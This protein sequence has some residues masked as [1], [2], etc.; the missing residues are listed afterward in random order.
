MITT[1]EL[2]L[3]LILSAIIGGLIGIEREANNRPAGLRTH[4]LV[5][6]GSALIM[7][8]STHGFNNLPATGD[9]ARLAA[10]VVSGIGF[11]GAGTILRTGNSIRGL[12]TAAS[13]WVC[14]GIGLAIGG[15]YY[16]GGLTTAGIVLFSL[17]SLG[18]FE[19]KI[20]TK[21]YKVL[22]IQC[23]ERLGLIGD[24][25]QVFGSYNIIIKD[26]QIFRNSD[27][28]ECEKEDVL[29]P[30]IILETQNLIEIHFAVKVCKDFEMKDFFDDVNRID[31]VEQVIWNDSKIAYK[32]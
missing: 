18:V 14:G 2:I 29:E 19:K 15:G 31:G 11:L 12:T 8:I 20:F 3:R 27:D 1:Y 28:V 22:I 26:I 17:M 32:T 4:I 25:G 9:P 7:L 21:K 23:R 13:I 5:T 6:L 16:L 30:T 10:Q 24:I